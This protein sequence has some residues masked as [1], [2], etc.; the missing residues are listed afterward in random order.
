MLCS[1]IYCY[2]NRWKTRHFPHKKIYFRP[3]Y[4]KMTMTFQMFFKYK[5]PVESL[6][7]ISN[8]MNGNASYQDPNRHLIHAPS[9]FIA[10]TFDLWPWPSKHWKNRNKHFWNLLV[11]MNSLI[12][13][14]LDLQWRQVWSLCLTK[15]VNKK[16]KQCICRRPLCRHLKLILAI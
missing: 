12:Y 5:R 10:L 1:S 3:F 2:I 16:W 14:N 9:I 4:T 11:K 7:G 6:F 8:Y 13:N 15:W